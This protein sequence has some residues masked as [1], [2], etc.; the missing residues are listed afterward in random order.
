VG[1]IARETQHIPDNPKGYIIQG[2]PLVVS[3]D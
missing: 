2:F 1:E 3:I